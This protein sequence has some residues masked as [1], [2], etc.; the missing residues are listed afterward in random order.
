M[1][2]AGVELYGPG[3]RWDGVEP[4]GGLDPLLFAEAARTSC[5]AVA[6]G[7]HEAFRSRYVS[8]LEAELARSAHAVRAMPGVHEILAT[9]RGRA[10]VIL[11]LLTGNYPEAAAL[12][13]RAISVDPAWFRV[14]AFGDQ[15]RSRSDLVEVAF[16]NHERIFG[17]KVEPEKVI[18]IGDT[19]KDV[20][21]ALQNGCVAF[22]VAT[23]RH[24]V[25]DLEA[26]GAHVAVKDLSDPAPLLALLDGI[27]EKAA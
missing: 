8:L 14:T 16:R 23:G 27:G 19:P 20:K 11:G 5:I 9:L 6:P 12:K 26:A 18:V 13:L 15:G 17:E 7:D 25:S 4:S 3:M 24:E 1:A 22:A 2:M 10:D 21:A